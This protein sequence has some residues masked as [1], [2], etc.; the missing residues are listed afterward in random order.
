MM[1]PL[2]Y[3]YELPFPL[4]ISFDD[5]QALFVSERES[6]KRQR[7]EDSSTCGKNEDYESVLESTPREV[8]V[9]PPPL[10]E[11]IQKPEVVLRHKVPL[12]FQ[13]GNPTDLQLTTASSMQIGRGPTDGRSPVEHGLCSN[14]YTCACC[15]LFIPH[16]QRVAYRVPYIKI[17]ILV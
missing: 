2:S 4:Q 16:K 15:V 13:R 8:V 9:S 6:I 3:D 1:V 5:F 17:I 11:S 14:H 7:L 10:D 12:R